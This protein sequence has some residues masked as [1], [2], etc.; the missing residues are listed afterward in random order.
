MRKEVFMNRD[1]EDWHKIYI[2]PNSD[3]ELSE[4]DLSKLEG[5]K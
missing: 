2:N 1:T 4:D 3:E 5:K